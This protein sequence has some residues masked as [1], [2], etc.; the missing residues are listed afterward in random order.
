VAL[1]LVSVALL[2]CGSS[3]GGGA[4]RGYTIAPEPKVD[5]A[6]LTDAAAQPAAPMELRA[7]PGGVLIV[8]FGYTSC[9]DVCP[10]TMSDVRK[11]L[12]ALGGRASKVDVAMVTVDPIRDTEQVLSGYVRSFVPTGHALRTT[13]DSLLRRVAGAFG[14]DYQVT[15]AADGTEQVAH[16]SLLYAVD[17]TGGLAVTWPFGT[18][19][20]DMAH[21]V[22]ILLR[23]AP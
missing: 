6:A 5:A 3:G 17:S 19:A 15:T 16:T 21:D 14:V 7:R 8:Y 23:S 13:D 20:A 12:G 1:A 11:A 4:L 10:T 18:T 22:G 9:P 2:G